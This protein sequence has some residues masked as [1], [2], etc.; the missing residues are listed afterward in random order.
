MMRHWLAALWISTGIAS[1]AAQTAEEGEA[2]ALERLIRAY[3][4]HLARIEGNDLVWK[5][6]T[7]MPLDDGRGPKSPETLLASADI[8]DMLRMPYGAGPMTATPARHADPGRAR[9]AAFF[10]K[11]YGDCTVGGV[12][13]KLVDVAWLPKKSGQKLK[14]SPVNGAAEKLAAVSR[15]L[16]ALPASFDRFLIPSAG[17]YV[18][19]TIAGTTRVS[20]HGHGIA[21]DIA[22]AGTDYWRWAKEKTT[23]TAVGD[24][25]YRNRVPA[26]IIEIFE[27][28][29][30]I[31]GGK[32]YHYDTMHFEYR[33]EL[34]ALSDKR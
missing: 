27:K 29:G 33:P 7:R 30:F 20:A 31:W 15:E 4:D 18:C 11:I 16:D 3:P 5:D 25:P 14:F 21:I 28:H 10:N 19:R 13:A 24:I 34:L 1:A 23:S 9:N 26:E 12:A 17:T 22:M 8:K 2:T 6:G 32:W